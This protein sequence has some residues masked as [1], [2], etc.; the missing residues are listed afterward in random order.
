MN[1]FWTIA[2]DGLK[3]F[4]F[5]LVTSISPAAGCRPFPCR[6]H[7]ADLGGNPVRVAA[8]RVGSPARPAVERGLPSLL[9]CKGFDRVGRQLEDF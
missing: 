3:A 4:A 1:T 8:A 7:P 6:E 5:W 2:N 9:W